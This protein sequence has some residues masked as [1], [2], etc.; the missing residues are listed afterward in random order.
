MKHQTDSRE[1]ID[2]WVEAYRG[3]MLKVA[4]SFRDAVHGAEDIV[5]Q[6]ALTALKAG[7]A[8]SDVESPRAWLM[9][10]TRTT[11]LQVVRKR[12]RRSK[13]RGA[14][15]AV[16]SPPGTGE[17]EVYLREQAAGPRCDFVLDVARRLPPACRE[18]VELML[19]DEMDDHEIAGHCGIKR[20]TVRSRR[21]RAAQ[22]IRERCSP[23]DAPDQS[24]IPSGRGSRVRTGDATDSPSRGI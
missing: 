11:G 17:A 22:M 2:R 10:L 23:P 1:R 20:T 24:V 18:V 4:R 5:Q 21:A 9:R 15:P 19:I 14:N 8:D 12:N 6:A 3:D 13:L 16:F 7:G